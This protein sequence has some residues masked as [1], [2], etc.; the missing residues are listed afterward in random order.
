MNVSL[1]FVTG[2]QRNESHP[3]IIRF[4]VGGKIRF[5]LSSFEE[6]S[7]QGECGEQRRDVIPGRGTQG[8]DA[9]PR[10]NAKKRDRL[11]ATNRG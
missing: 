2:W 5:A 9:V 11:T 1:R 8:G 7:E 3:D 10:N 6:A 4:R